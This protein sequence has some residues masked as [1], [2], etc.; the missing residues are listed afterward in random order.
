MIHLSHEIQ[1][2]EDAD[3]RARA[4]TAGIGKRPVFPPDDALAGLASF[5]EQL[6]DRGRD[7]EETLELLD[8][9]GTPATVETNGGR[10]FGF[11]TGASLPV[12]AAAERL[13]LAWDNAGLGFITSPTAAKVEAIAARWVLDVLDLPPQSGVGFTTS[14]GAGTVIALSAARRSLLRRHGWDIDE[15]GLIGAPALRVVASASAHV[16]VTKA[17]RVLGFG[18][19]QIHLAATDEHGRIDPGALPP[20]DAMTIVVLQA[21]EVNTGEFDPFGEIIPA[22]RA[23]GAWV[24][25]DG[26]FGLWARASSAHRDLTDG[27]DGAD[28]WTVD[29]HKWLNTPY[30]SAMVILAD[31]G[32]LAEAMNSDAAYSATSAASQKNLTLEFSR[33]PRGIAVWAALRTLGRD[34][35]AELVDRTVD[36]ATRMADELRDAGYTVL[37]RGVINQIVASAG[38]A[39]ETARIVA[40]A[41]ASGR[42]WFGASVWRGQPVM[43]ISVSSWRT[44]AADVD[45]LLDLLRELKKNSSDQT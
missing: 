28:S 3:R 5:D 35:V 8:G 12:A 23:A 39:E 29:G 36:M 25:V 32:V 19:A 20:I 21:G 18:A 16:V 38:T 22:A 9:Y 26:A 10:Y 1:L 31:P 37:S 13:V 2:L 33:R 34:G 30:D 4:Y 45:D 27:V 24:H 15:H 17:L 44:T 43:R 40:A 11:V 14:A 7:A 6:P 41:Q 42:T